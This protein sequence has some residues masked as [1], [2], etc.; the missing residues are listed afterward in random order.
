[1]LNTACDMST[2]TTPPLVCRVEHGKLACHA[3]LQRGDLI[4][5]V[6]GTPVRNWFEFFDAIRQSNGQTLNAVVRRNG[7]ELAVA[8]HPM[9]DKDEDGQTV[10]RIGM[11]AGTEW[12][13]KEMS[14][15]A[16]VKEATDE[17]IGATG[18]LMS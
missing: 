17:T 12:A 2:Y 11:A 9:Q 5:S 1:M 15:A 4:V 6:N 16:S 14:L 3:G 7:N 18:K 13:F 10:W 8:I